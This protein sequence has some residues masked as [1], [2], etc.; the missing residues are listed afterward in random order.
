[1]GWPSINHSFLSPSGKMSKRAHKKYLDRFTKELF[2]NGLPR[3]LP[4]Q[5]SEKDRLLAQAKQLRELAERG[6]CTRKY[7]KRAEELE[8]QALNESG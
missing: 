8:E 2:P 3:A 5:P 4:K 7:T 1:M 6:M